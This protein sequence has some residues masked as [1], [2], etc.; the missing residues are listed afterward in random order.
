VENTVTG[1]PTPSPFRTWLV[2]TLVLPIFLSACT[3]AN[4]A[5]QLVVQHHV[6]MVSGAIDVLSGETEAREQR[7]EHLYAELE[8]SGLAIAAEQDQWRLLDQLR[9]HVALQDA[10]LS[11]LLPAASHP[12]HDQRGDPIENDEGPP[13]PADE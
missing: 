7:L 4:R 9:R 2:A 1:K 12:Q 11:E 3:T 13:D 5:A 10:L 8:A 6:R